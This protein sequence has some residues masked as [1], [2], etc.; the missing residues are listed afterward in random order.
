MLHRSH[1][2]RGAALLASILALALAAACLGGCLG[3][4]KKVTVAA[5]VGGT[6][7][8]EE[9]VTAYI[10]GFRSQDD[11]RTTDAGWSQYLSSNG[12]T[13]ESFRLKVLNDVFIPQASVKIQAAAQGI[14]VTDEELDGVIAAEKAYYEDSYGADSWTSVLASYGYD[15][16]SWR[17]SE[18]NRL[19]QERLEDAVIG[20]VVPTG[21]DMAE[22]APSIAPRFNG[23]HSYYIA[24][25][26]EESAEQALASLGGA[27]AS[28][29]LAAFEKLAAN[30]QEL[31][32]IEEARQE[33]EG[34]DQDP[35]AAAAYS[36]AYGMCDAGWGSL[37]DTAQNSNNIYTN[38]LNKLEL[39][40]VS[41][42]VEPEKGSWVIIYCDEAYV[43][44][45]R[46]LYDLEAVP[47]NIREAL[48][49]AVADQLRDDAFD[50]WLKEA[51]KGED[52]VIND[53]P[54]GLSYDVSNKMV[55]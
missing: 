29:K 7:I 38:A 17:E 18:M 43:F 23:K 44:Q 15:E 3:L 19:L 32:L 28:V 11:D 30:V 12:Y 21:D 9:D 52:I 33:E 2:H 50:A 54:S 8:S 34:E 51:M 14:V 4:S 20:E 6:V 41:E 25:E 42:V 37:T 36:P 39:G 47:D 10:E 16:E 27:D 24:F 31:A 55:Q 13:A 45:E 26:S 40:T 53:M 22:Y 1:R 35:E 5:T 48:V 49:E 46:D